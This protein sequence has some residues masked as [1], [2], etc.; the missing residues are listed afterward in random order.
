MPRI[1]NARPKNSHGRLTLYKDLKLRIM[2]HH[3]I[4]VAR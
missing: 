3:M 4:E 2:S 1:M